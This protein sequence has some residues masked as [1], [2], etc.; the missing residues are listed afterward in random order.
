MPEDTLFRRV[1]HGNQEEGESNHGT[2]RLD[3]VMTP[4][5]LNTVGF[6]ADWNIW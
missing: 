1:E 4:C 3:K 6:A 5:S 2:Q